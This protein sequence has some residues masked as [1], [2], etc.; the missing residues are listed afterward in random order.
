MKIFLALS[1]I[2]AGLAFGLSVGVMSM[3][4]PEYEVARGAAIGATVFAFIAYLTWMLLTKDP[5]IVQLSIGFITCIAIFVGLPLGMGWINGIETRNLEAARHATDLARTIGKLSPN[6]VL[7][8][9]ENNSGSQ[10]LQVGRS[11]TIFN[12]GGPAGLP[13]FNFYGS[14]ILIETIDGEVKVSTQIKDSS[15]KLYAELIRNEWQTAIRPQTWDRNYSKD[16][17]EVINPGGKVVLQVRALPDRIQMQ[18]EW[19]G[20]GGNGLKLVEEQS[21]GGSFVALLTASQPNG[22]PNVPDIKRMFIYPSDSH[23]GELK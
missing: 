4:P 21:G 9:T 11:G 3:S 16:S 12:Y 17:L 2:I 7:F 15:G 19:W 6:S 14:K 18:G 5:L 20:E 13:L 10:M 8:S 1:A 23:L 22:P